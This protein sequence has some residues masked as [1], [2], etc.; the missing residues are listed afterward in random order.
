MLL[1]LRIGL[2]TVVLALVFSARAAT[3][4]PG[5]E[6]L[7]A[8]QRQIVDT[9]STIFNAIRAEDIEKLDSVSLKVRS[10]TELWIPIYQIHRDVRWFSKPE[11][12][13]PHRWNDSARRLK[14]AYF[15]FGGGLRSCI[16]QHFAMA[17]LVLGL[18]VILSRFRFRLEPGTKL[19]ADA[20]QTLRPKNRMPVVIS[21]R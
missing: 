1:R 17:Q 5:H 6:G 16:A 10:G 19:E 3:E 11:R 7:S 21:A 13:D 8:Q 20:W 2:A 15:P 14:Y 18:A 9:I 4:K 12:F